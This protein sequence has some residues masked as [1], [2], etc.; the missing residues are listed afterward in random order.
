MLGKSGYVYHIRGIF[1]RVLSYTNGITIIF[2]RIGVLNEMLEICN[3]Y[4]IENENIFNKKK[5][6]SMHHTEGSRASNIQWIV[7]IMDR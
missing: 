3:Q 7:L 4:A 6:N 2:P 1:S 5:K